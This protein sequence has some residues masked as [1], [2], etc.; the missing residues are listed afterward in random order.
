M[1][2]RRQ[3]YTFSFF[4]SKKDAEKFGRNK[5]LLNFA[6]RNIKKDFMNNCM[7]N[8]WWWRNSRLK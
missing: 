7:Y 4:L 1:I 8:I 3:I 6:P 5:N 2:N